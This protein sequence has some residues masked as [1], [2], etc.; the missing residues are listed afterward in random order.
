MG[1]ADG[2]IDDDTSEPEGD[3]NA[4]GRGE[5]TSRAQR[6]RQAVTRDELRELQDQL[7]AF[8]SEIEDRTVHREELEDDLK[9]YVRG[10]VR[11]GHATGWG[12]Y[13]V[14]LYGTVMTLGAFYF[15]GGGWAILAMLVIWLS[16]LGLYALMVL[17]GVTVKA[18]GA[19]GR[20]L[21]KLRSLR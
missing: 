19:P 14:L 18:V 13:L 9:Q 20:I 10:R 2:P 1:E 8:E 4:S 7:E 15:L 5:R 6:E 12:P 16:T 3:R 11:R 17:V 21:D